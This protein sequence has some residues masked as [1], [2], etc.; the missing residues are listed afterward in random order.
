[1]YAISYRSSLPA[2]F[3]GRLPG[4]DA[5]V[6]SRR[7]TLRTPARGRRRRRAP[8]R[9]RRLDTRARSI[10]RSRT[11]RAAAGPHRG[12]RRRRVRRSARGA[13]RGG[14]LR[15]G[16]HRR[17]R[18]LPGPVAR[19]ARRRAARRSRPATRRAAPRMVL[20][21]S[22][23]RHLDARTR[24]IV[25]RLRRLADCGR[26]VVRTAIHRAAD[27]RAHPAV[28]RRFRAPRP[29]DRQRDR[30]ARRD[31]RGERGLL[32]RERIPPRGAARS[33][34]L[35]REI[36][37][38]PAGVL[39]RT[40]ADHHRGADLD[41]GDLQSAQGRRVLLGALDDRPGARRLGST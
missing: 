27:P 17:P 35:D 25:A 36:G 11:A 7:R 23:P 20:H 2:N 3:R 15:P 26:I 37:P 9:R 40:L 18:S 10:D 16:S 12:G 4:N 28:P 6:L 34:A 29:D 33:A 41:R 14:P 30:C 8:V 13:R 1:M 24:S 5:R 31:R 21:A 38:P 22:R 19:V 39:R 32:P